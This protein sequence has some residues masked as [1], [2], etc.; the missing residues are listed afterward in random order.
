M[1]RSSSVPPH[2]SSRLAA[3]GG[4]S[5]VEVLAAVV[6]FVAI[7]ASTIT[8]LLMALKTVR[9][10]NDRVLVANVARSQIEELRVLGPDQIVPGLSEGPK[11]A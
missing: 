8:V 4:F 6:L 11:A 1:V 5:L 3:D 2:P 7:S 10:N 9:E